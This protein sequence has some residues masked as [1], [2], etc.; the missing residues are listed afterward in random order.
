MTF[1]PL[2]LDEPLVVATQPAFA[3]DAPRC[4]DTPTSD[5]LCLG[6]IKNTTD[7]LWKNISLTVQLQDRSQR[8]SLEQTYLMPGHAAPYRVIWPSSDIHEESAVLL[9]LA[10]QVHAGTEDVFA[11]VAQDIDGFWVNKSRYR[12]RGVLKNP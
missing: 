2:L 5:L 12:V 11:I 6:Q 7:R 4:Y 3:Y 9:T 1:T 10:P 8:V